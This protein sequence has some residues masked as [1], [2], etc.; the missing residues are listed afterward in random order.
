MKP[1]NLDLLTKHSWPHYLHKYFSLFVCLKLAKS[2]AVS[3]RNTFKIT[4]MG[5]QI[6]KELWI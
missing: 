4:E 2:Q 6:E 5:I 1:F 3:S